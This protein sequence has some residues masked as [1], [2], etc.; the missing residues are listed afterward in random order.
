MTARTKRLR[1]WVVKHQ[2]PVFITVVLIV[3]TALTG[4]SMWLYQTSGAAKLDL[5][6]PGY[7][8]IRED[9][10]D[11]GD[12]TKPFSPTGTLN[13]E[14]V[15]DFRSRYENIKSRLNQMNNYDNA[16]M[17]DENLGLVIGEAVTEP[18]E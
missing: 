12:N 5:S 3:T 18:I 2:W 10:K 17:S 14:A 13:K 6:R 7:E 11:G 9:V 4:V 16:V 15:A 8:K 1:K